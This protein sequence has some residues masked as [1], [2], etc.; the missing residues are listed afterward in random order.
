MLA[1]LAWSLWREPRPEPSL[2]VLPFADLTPGAAS[3]PLG[4]GLTDE[5][6]AGLATVPGLTVIAP[7]S[8]E[9]YGSSVASLP[10]IAREL[11]VAHVLHGTVKRS[12]GQV[13]VTARLVQAER[14]RVLWSRTYDASTDGIAPVLDEIAHDVVRALEVKLVGDST[15]TLV[16]RQTRNPEAY[17]LYQQ[18]RFHWARRTIEG[19]RQAHAYFE[20]AL[21]LDSG[22]ADAYAGL[23]DAHLTGWHHGATELTEEDVRV[24][25]TRAAE[26]ALSLDPASADAHTSFAMSLW[27]QKNWPGAERELRRA[28]ELSPNHARARNWLAQLIAAMG[29]EEEALREARRAAEL[30][31]FAVVMVKSWGWHCYL[32]RDWDCA[33]EQLERSLEL[34]PSFAQAI[35]YLAMVEAMRGRHAEAEAAMRKVL[36]LEPEAGHAQAELA[37][38]QARAGNPAA[39][40]RSLQRAIGRTSDF[41][42][43]R[44]W[45]AL[46]ERDSAF[47][48]L[49]RYD[50]WKWPHRGLL[51]DPIFDPLRGD[52]RFVA[53]EESVLR[54]M[55]VR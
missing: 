32:V 35:R 52:A 54:E 41:D 14:E 43:A 48:A 8:A 49:K 25:M 46:G 6:I 40:R 37:I 16:R 9:R 33:V 1:L 28:V 7:T 55:A 38:V 26:R 18:G 47:A 44:A 30:D 10:E 11:A 31:P 24:R 3:D 53:L 34:D 20:R 5:I 36:L 23:A 39:A 12:G 27:W 2:V 19:H 21:A 29:R 45:A 50:G 17:A 51:A 22:Y 13:R 15:R 42:L 4:D